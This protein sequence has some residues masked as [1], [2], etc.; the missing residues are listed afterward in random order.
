MENASP[1][2]KGVHLDRVVDHQVGRDQ[3][4]DPLRIAAQL[5]QGVAHDRQGPP[6]PVPR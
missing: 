1:L 5:G 4:V 3:R 6:Q 2:P